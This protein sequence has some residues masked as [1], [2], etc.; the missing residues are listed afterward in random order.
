MH[1]QP[2]MPPMLVSSSLEELEQGLDLIRQELHDGACQY[3]TA[4]VAMLEAFRQREC[5]DRPGDSSEITA[6]VRLLNRAGTELRRLV[7]GRSPF[8]LDGDDASRSV[9]SLVAEYRSA[10]G[11]EIEFCHDGDF[12]GLPRSCHIAIVRIVQECLVNAR[13]HS[14]SRRILVGLARDSD[15]ISIQVQ[16]WGIG[17]VP[18]EAENGGYGL[19]SIRRRAAFLGGSVTFDTHPGK[20][21]CV[22]VE[23]PL[24]HQHC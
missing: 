12:Y 22:L 13:R 23:M 1:H 9:E 19:K 16:D 2:E 21:T 10:D 11:P 3:V 6:V 14:Q 4:A 5:D 17:F 18:A 8:C 20:G 7:S 24:P 15:R